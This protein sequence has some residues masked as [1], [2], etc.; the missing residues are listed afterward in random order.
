M[1]YL[2]LIFATLSASAKAII[3]KK[4][5]QDNKNVH[6]VLFLN[7]NIFAVASITILICNAGKVKSFFEISPFSLILAVCFAFFLLFTQITQIFA[8]SRGFASL[9]S[10][11]YSCGFLI[12]I[13]FSAIFLDEGI[14]PLQT[15]GILLLLVALV[16]ILPPER[17]G[18]FSF[19][20]L[21]FALMSMLGSGINAVIQKLHQSSVYKDELVPFLFF[22]LLFAAVLSLAASFVGK[23]KD[24][25]PLSLLYSQ[26]SAVL[27]MILGGVIVGGMNV[28]N[29]KLAG[30]LPAVIQFP[31]YNISSMII[32]AL[33]GR[34][35]FGER[36]GKRKLA[37]FIVG[38]VAITVIGIF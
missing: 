27:L 31:V 35:L 24:S 37:G 1:K 14:S 8:M 25:S 11:I 10:L 15:V 2:L 18:R 16:V 38:L 22:A 36:I 30:Q 28:V 13:F 9:S 7:A 26:K 29:L 6:G 5:G 12:P 33:A 20:W 21:A 3:C 17:S 23:K 19:V 32:T 4:I 34:V